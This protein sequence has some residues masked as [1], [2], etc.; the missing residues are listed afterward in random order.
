MIWNSESVLTQI[1]PNTTKVVLNIR[2]QPDTNKPPVVKVPAGVR[3]SYND[4][5]ND[6]EIVNGNSKGFFYQ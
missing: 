1:C 4:F 6:G 5:T 2:S 3:L